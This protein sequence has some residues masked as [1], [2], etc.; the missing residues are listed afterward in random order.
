MAD[1]DNGNVTVTTEEE[2]PTM[3][4][5]AVMTAAARGG[6]EVH[7]FLRDW[8]PTFPM[9]EHHVDYIGSKLRERAADWYVWFHDIRGLKLRDVQAFM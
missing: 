2:V 4:V 1:D 8:G 6:A 9:D 5:T 7:K 3:M